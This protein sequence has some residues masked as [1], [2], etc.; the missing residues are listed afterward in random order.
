MAHRGELAEMSIKQL[1][2]G[3]EAIAGKGHHTKVRQDIGEAPSFGRQ[4]HDNK[5]ES[6]KSERLDKVP[7]AVGKNRHARRHL[8]H[9]GGVAAEATEKM[10]LSAMHFDWFDSAQ[11]LLGFTV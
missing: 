5:N 9:D 11:E 6:A 7:W 3:K 1:Q 8:R 4:D 2:G 10:F